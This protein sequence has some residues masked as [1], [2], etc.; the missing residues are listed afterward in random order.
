MFVYENRYIF[1]TWENIHSFFS[2]KYK[3]TKWRIF[4]NIVF[5]HSEEW[6]GNEES[7][8]YRNNNI[9][10]QWGVVCTPSKRRDDGTAMSSSRVSEIRV[11]VFCLVC[12][13][14]RRLLEEVLDCRK[15]Y[16]G[17]LR[18]TLEDQKDQ[19]ATLKTMAEQQNVVV[20]IR[21]ECRCY[22]R[23]EYDDFD[24]EGQGDAVELVEWLRQINTD[25]RS[26]KKVRF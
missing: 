4:K 17:L 18:K 21:G 1:R 24:Y 15:S 19:T 6:A 13:C 8:I 12:R 20:A 10:V 23:R 2:P 26:I 9:N 16:N 3:H 14:F 5:W 25:E 22:D 7:T 11:R